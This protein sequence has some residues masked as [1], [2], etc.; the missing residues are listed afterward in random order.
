MTKRVYVKDIPIGGNAPITVQSMTDTPT[1]DTRA[2]LECIS[3][4]YG[5]GCDIVRVSV[6]DREALESLKTIVKLSPIPVVADIH[7]DYEL[8]LGAVLA[9]AHKVRINPSNFP[10]YCLKKFASACV[11]RHTPIRIGVNEGSEKSERTPSELAHLAVATSERLMNYGLEDI[12]LAVKTS[13]VLKTI[14]AYRELSKLTDLPLHVGL[15]EAGTPK[16]GIA[17]STIAI[18]SLL[19][20]G[21]GDTV[22]VSLS[23]NPVQ[24]VIEG[25]KILRAVGLD[26]RFT[27]VIA[28][29]TCS[30]TEIDVKGIA[31]KL[32][33]LTENSHK[34]LKMA[35]MGCIVNGV[36][37]SR[38]AD[39]GVC[40]GKDKSAIYIKGQK[41]KTVNNNDILKELYKLWE[42]YDG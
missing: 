18:G 5:A 22:R 8:A 40:G 26:N 37:E 31:S 2:T 9:G 27:E 36:G 15:T 1:G 23:A 16:L 20:D 35:V 19:A 11:E 32:E 13:D 39:I 41:F 42:E 17:K 4:L 25:R 29:P 34:S 12:V 7:F 24:E 38:G 10:D 6:P 30:R 33:Q 28:C 21:I 3:K 14:T